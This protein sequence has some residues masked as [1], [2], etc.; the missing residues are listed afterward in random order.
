M[1]QHIHNQKGKNHQRKDKKEKTFN[2]N[3]KNLKMRITLLG[4]RERRV[5]KV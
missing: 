2:I 5:K 4:I 1:D 3:Y